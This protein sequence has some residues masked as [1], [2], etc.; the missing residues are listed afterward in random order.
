MQC[1]NERT[2]GD[3]DQGYGAKHLGPWVP[4]LPGPISSPLPV[5][6]A[7]RCGTRIAWKVRWGWEEHNEE[8][9]RGISTARATDALRRPHAQV[10]GACRS[11][12]GNGQGGQGPIFRTPGV[13]AGAT[14]SR[15]SCRV[16]ETSRSARHPSTAGGGRRAAHDLAIGRRGSKR[17]D[18][19]GLGSGETGDS[20]H[21]ISPPTHRPPP[22][23]YRTTV[24]PRVERSHGFPRE[25]VWLI[26]EPTC[27][28]A[29]QR[30][31]DR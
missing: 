11:R 1:Q 12:P 13:P 26:T 3:A 22:T 27:T 25:A 18:H 20:N 5:P 30:D 8:S 31:E 6:A 15:E 7:S 17:C 9:T 2:G 4:G 10:V 19:N 16:W 21:I 14:A 29:V 23:A 24:P 28:H